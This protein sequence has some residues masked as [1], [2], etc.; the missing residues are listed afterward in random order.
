[1]RD[2]PFLY[3]CSFKFFHKNKK[4]KSCK[5]GR[6]TK[7]SSEALPQELHRQLSLMEIKATTGNFHENFKISQGDFRCIYKGFINDGTLAVA[8]KRL[9]PESW[10][11][12]HEFQNEMRLLYQLSHPNLVSLVG[13]ARRKMK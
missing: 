13:S 9:H 12:I 4:E 2:L 5:S 7:S 11:G 10:M 8:V 1:M 3:K 6:K